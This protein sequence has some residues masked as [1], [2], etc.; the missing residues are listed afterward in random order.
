MMQ[1]ERVILR[2]HSPTSRPMALRIPWEYSTSIWSSGT[3]GI[4]R[5]PVVGT[6]ILPEALAGLR[7]MCL[8]PRV[9]PRRPVHIPTIAPISINSGRVAAQKHMCA[10]ILS[11][12]SGGGRGVRRAGDGLVDPSR[13]HLGELVP[14]RGRRGT[15][16]TVTQVVR[17]LAAGIRRKGR[18]RR[19]R[20]RVCS[21]GL[22]VFSTHWKK[23]AGLIKK[24]AGSFFF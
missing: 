24:T 2:S 8:P 16:S 12:A 11:N 9:A 10:S 6:E 20:G 22:N 15:G 4:R 1:N 3:E 7:L 13:L 23:T 21:W 19:A 5:P 18:E 14:H 17:L